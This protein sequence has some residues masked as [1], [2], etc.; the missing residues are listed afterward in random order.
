VSVVLV[1]LMAASLAFF[2][3]TTAPFVYQGF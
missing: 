2:A 1:L 3:D